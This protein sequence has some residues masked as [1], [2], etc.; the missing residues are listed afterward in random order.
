MG[1]GPP[2]DFPPPP[3]VSNPN[4]KGHVMSVEL[5]FFG[6][7]ALFLGALYLLGLCVGS[8]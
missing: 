8:L 6:Y 4:L 1:A 3:P 5:R 2:Q 7:L